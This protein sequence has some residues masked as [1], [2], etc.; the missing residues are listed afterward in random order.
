MCHHTWLY[1]Y[2]FDKHDDIFAYVM[3]E[4]LLWIKLSRIKYTRQVT[5][6]VARLVYTNPE[7]SKSRQKEATDSHDSNPNT[8][9]TEATG[10]GLQDQS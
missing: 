8:G 4:G 9:E 6:S 1:L 7:S 3:L 2:T 5:I 10:S